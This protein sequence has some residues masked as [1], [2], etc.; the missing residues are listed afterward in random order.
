[1]EQQSKDTG[2]MPSEEC[3]RLDGDLH[4]KEYRPFSPL[5]LYCIEV[6]KKKKNHYPAGDN[7]LSHRQ[8]R[9]FCMEVDALI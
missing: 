7:Y 9:S 6:A 8:F 1:M 3:C 2:Y 5:T 4:L